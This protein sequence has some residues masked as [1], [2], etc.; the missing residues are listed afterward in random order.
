[1]KQPSIYGRN[2]CFSNVT[3]WSTKRVINCS[4]S[5]YM[6]NRWE[7]QRNL[8]QGSCFLWW[9]MRT[10]FVWVVF[11]QCMLSSYQNEPPKKTLS[12][13]YTTCPNNIRFNSVRD[14]WYSHLDY[15]TFMM[16]FTTGKAIT[17]SSSF[18]WNMR[19]NVCKDPTINC[20]NTK[21][22]HPSL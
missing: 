14:T 10:R 3:Y 8:L 19:F 7:I 18:L 17:L 21:N 11:R 9:F 4:Y 2:G 6:D 12:H 15:T 22:T 16:S 13:N 20:K 1:M 5:G